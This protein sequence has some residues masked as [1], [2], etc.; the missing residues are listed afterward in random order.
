MNDQAQL[1]EVNERFYEAFRTRDDDAMA[2]VWAEE[3][4]CT[5]IHPGW[6]ALS[7]RDGVLASFSAIFKNP[8]APEVYCT[9]PHV[10]VYGGVG[11]IIC[12]ESLEGGSLVAT[13][14]FRHE[15][16]VWR[17]VHHHAG[18]G[19]SVKREPELDP[20]AVLH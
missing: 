16:G 18:P 10:E 5:V 8:A 3:A 12:D 7:G 17:M 4:P 14:V 2:A 1:L 11:V 19:Q 20:G 15:A 6:V 13:N 9:S